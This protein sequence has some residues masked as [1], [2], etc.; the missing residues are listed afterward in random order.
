M[1][2]WPLIPPTLYSRSALLAYA[3]NGL[4]LGLNAVLGW[5]DRATDWP[6]MM[7]CGALSLSLCACAILVRRMRSHWRIYHEARRLAKEIEDAREQ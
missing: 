2:R 5:R 6:L 7:N 1:K 3:T 4:S